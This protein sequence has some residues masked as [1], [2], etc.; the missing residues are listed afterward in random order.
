MHNAATTAVGYV[1]RSS[2]KQD[3]SLNQQRAKLE[4]FAESNGWAL[5]TVY[6]DDAISGS[7]MKR[8]GLAQLMAD[9]EQNPGP[10]I[11]LAWDR[12]RLARPK[13]PIDGLLLER[14]LQD[15]GKR[16]IYAATGAEADGSFTSGLVGYI[17]HHQN[18]DYLRKLSRDTMR[19]TVD[20]AKRGQWPGGPI[21]FGF[22]RLI[23]DGDTPRVIVRDLDDGTQAVL[24]PSTG[25]VQQH[26]PKGKRFKKQDH[27]ICTLTLSTP[28]R[29]AAVAKLFADHAAGLPTRK[30]RD[31]LNAAGFRTSRGNAFTIQTL[32]PMLENWAYV[33]DCVYNQR[34][35]SKWHRYHDGQSVER[36]DAG[37]EKR[38]EDDWIVCDNAWPAIVDRETFEA[39]QERR[40][41][42]RE[43]H[44]HARGRALK[45]EYLL[46]GLMRCGVCGGKLTG[47][48]MKNQKGYRNRYYTCA[49]HSAGHKHECPKR[50]YVPADLV[51]QHVLQ[52]IR[53]DLATLR[54]DEKL[55]ERIADELRRMTG[56]RADAAVQL[57]RRLADL[58]QQVAKLRDHLMAMQPAV[59]ES[60]GLYQQAEQLTEDRKQVEQELAA[61]PPE[62]H[63][64]PPTDVIRQRAA[65]QFDR[66]GE[67]L[68][69]GTLEEKRELIGA[70]VQT[71]KAD[72]DLGAVMIGLYAT[73]ASQ[74]IAGSGFEPLTSGL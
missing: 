44:T 65:A 41:T 58:D 61:L 4:A 40:K 54:D 31:Q 47:H 11:V 64:L 56:G 32:H 38:P 5:K 6:I 73:L 10:G 57:R 46:T 63:D 52:L 8:A 30:L 43:K 33:G 13:D 67:L 28:E 24:D 36:R 69:A 7:D 9:A 72:P 12:N 59:A 42:S 16:I 51:E 14:R 22:D 23:L 21:P 74:F 68:Q 29:V 1:R 18:G 26:L 48:G 70:Y 2:D 20:R 49:R 45:S 19:G 39:V 3:E 71:I 25:D 62:T 50:F 35:L 15:A 53:E 34:T 37:V 17:E 55:H 27:E 66:L 60:M